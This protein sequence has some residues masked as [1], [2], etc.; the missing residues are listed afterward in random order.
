[1]D[2]DVLAMQGHQLEKFGPHTLNVNSLRAK[3]SEEI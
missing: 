3:F 1:M 2:A